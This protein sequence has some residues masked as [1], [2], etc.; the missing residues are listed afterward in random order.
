MKKLICAFI[1]LA[2]LCCAALA[3]Q[4]GLPEGKSVDGVSSASTVYY[5][6][7]IDGDELM[8]AINSYTGFY[9]VASVNSDGT[10][11]IAYFIYAMAKL[12]GEYYLQLGLSPNQTTLNIENGSDLMAMYGKSP[13]LYPYASTGA[14][15]Y[16]K[17]V[18]DENELQ[19]LSAFSPAGYTPLYYRVVNVVPMG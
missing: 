7:A 19:A 1:C 3:E 15:M 13:E 11:N 6:D 4:E 9:A 5:F 8:D 12:D 18:E 17:K 10:P 14:R 16:L 2:L